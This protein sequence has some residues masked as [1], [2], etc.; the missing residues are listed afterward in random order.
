MV[1]DGKVLDE[2]TGAGGH[3]FPETSLRPV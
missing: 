3:S 1:Q 2:A